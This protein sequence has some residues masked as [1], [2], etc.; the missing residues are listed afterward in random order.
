M[1]SCV[2]LARR[3]AGL[4]RPLRL[5][6]LIIVAGMIFYISSQP[7]VPTPPLFPHQDK[8]FHFLEFAGLG[9]MVFLNRDSWGR[10]PLPVMV[11]LVVVYALSDEIHQSF[12]PGRDCSAADLAADAAGGVTALLLLSRFRSGKGSPG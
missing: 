7:A 10:R 6:G 2:P 9:L 3:I 1:W 11:L 4:P 8:V 12:V 5:A